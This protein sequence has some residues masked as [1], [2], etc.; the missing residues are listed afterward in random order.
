MG[1]GG[2][3]HRECEEE[4]QNVLFHSKASAL[5]AYHVGRVTLTPAAPDLAA[6]WIRVILPGRTSARIRRWVA[7]KMLKNRHET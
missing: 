6:V 4:Q 3:E 1:P 7:F 2:E 5:I